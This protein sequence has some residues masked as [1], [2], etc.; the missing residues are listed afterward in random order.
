MVDAS[1]I[2]AGTVL[3]QS[4]DKDIEHPACYFSCKFDS[5]Q[6]NYSTIEKLYFLLF[7]IL[8]IIETP[9]YFQLQS[10]LIIIL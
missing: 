10:W 1:D 7:N 6:K 8:M 4:D 5:H 3:M 2:G 9:Y